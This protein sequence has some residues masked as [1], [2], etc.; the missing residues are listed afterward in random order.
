M[1][2][3]EIHNTIAAI[4]FLDTHKINSFERVDEESKKANQ[5]LA[6]ACNYL[7]KDLKSATCSMMFI[8]G[9]TIDLAK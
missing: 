6:S 1:N 3:N 5:T 7:A 9:T 2:Y 8:L 4:I